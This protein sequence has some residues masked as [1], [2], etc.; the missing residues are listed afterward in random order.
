[1]AKKNIEKAPSMRKNAVGTAIV[2]LFAG[3]PNKL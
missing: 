2:N 3:V 1:M